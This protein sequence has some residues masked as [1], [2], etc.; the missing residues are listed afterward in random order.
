MPE[1]TLIR[2]IAAPPERVF[3]YITQTERLMEWWGH[4]TTTVPDHD[5]SFESA[6]RPWYSVLRFGDGREM[7][8]SGHVT[9]VDAPRSVG[10]TWAWHDADGTRGVETHVTIRVAPDGADGTEV[11]LTHVDLPDDDYAARQMRGWGGTLDRLV[12]VAQN[13]R[14]T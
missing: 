7:K 1:L 10:F 12:N 4:E 11:T 8:M 3:R 13:R 5:L 6:G 2:Q 9:H 14:R